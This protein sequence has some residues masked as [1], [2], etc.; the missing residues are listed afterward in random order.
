MK[1]IDDLKSLAVP[2]DSIKLDDQNAVNHPQ[3]NIEMIA[4]SLK[5]YGQRKPIVVNKKTNIV[6]A[7]NGTLTAA[8][9]LGAKEIAAVFVTESKKNAQGFSVLDN[10][11]AQLAKFNPNLLDIAK[12]FEGEED[13]S[14]GF[15]PDE[16]DSMFNTEKEMKIKDNIEEMEIQP[17][18]HHDYIVLI[19]K[20]TLSWTKVLTFFGIKK[21]NFSTTSKKVKIG[22]GRVIKGEKL[23]DYIDSQSGKSK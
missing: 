11:S 17:F 2:V 18:E 22:L 9:M 4:N 23:L 10:R 7:G 13:I 14:L 5:K 1:I 6:E 16:L 21:V 20:D 12:L 3:R 19:F 15:R 8:R